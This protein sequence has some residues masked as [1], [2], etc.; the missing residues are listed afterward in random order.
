MHNVLLLCEYAT[1]GGGEHSMLAAL[2]GIQAAGFLPAVIAPPQG[3]LAEALRARDCELLPWIS[4]DEAGTRLSQDRLRSQLARLLRR[5]RVDLLHANSLSM[6]RLS[7][8]VAAEL[9]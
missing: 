6:G 2:A 7:G 9:Q 4:H 5:R 1:L 3:P 8:P